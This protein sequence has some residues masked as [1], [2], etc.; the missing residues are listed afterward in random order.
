MDFVQFRKLMN[1]RK[2]YLIKNY[3][4]K[5]PWENFNTYMTLGLNYEYMECKSNKDRNNAVS[6]PQGDKSRVVKSHLLSRPTR[7][8]SL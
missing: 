5:V 6:L 4:K 2:Y 3:E 1:E 8:M 7:R